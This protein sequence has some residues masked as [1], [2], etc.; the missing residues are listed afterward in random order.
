MI[1]KIKN[2]N[3]R[4][5]ETVSFPYS[6]LSLAIAEVL[7]KEGYVKNVTKKGKK[8]VKTLEVGL[9]YDDAKQP[10]VTDVKRVSKSSKRIYVGSSEIKGVKSG[11]GTL[12]LTTPNGILTDKQAKAAKVGGEALFKIW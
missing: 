5:L 11:F 9:V 3:L 12:V 7:E 4:G 2:A 10:R 8:V 1:I 6:K